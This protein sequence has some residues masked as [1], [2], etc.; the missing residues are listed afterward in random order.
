MVSVVIRIA[1]TSWLDRRTLEQLRRH[2]DI[3]RKRWRWRVARNETVRMA[4]RSVGADVPDYLRR[5]AL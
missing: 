4:L 5:Q 3:E 1:I 2:D